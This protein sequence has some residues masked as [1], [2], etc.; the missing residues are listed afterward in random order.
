MG[1]HSQLQDPNSLQ[2]GSKTVWPF[3]IEFIQ[4]LN[5]ALS[6]RDATQFHSSGPCGSWGT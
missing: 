1:E 3:P 2:A 6:Q 5:N 4:E